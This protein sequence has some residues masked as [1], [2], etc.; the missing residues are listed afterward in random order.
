MSRYRR[1]PK[2]TCAEC[3][4]SVPLGRVFCRQCLD[5]DHR[6]PM[7]PTTRKEIRR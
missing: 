5:R 4:R 2:L 3:N 6:L 7:R 1:R